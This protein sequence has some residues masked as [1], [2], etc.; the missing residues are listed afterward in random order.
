MR[1]DLAELLDSSSIPRSRIK[2]DNGIA[3]AF[4]I[5]VLQKNDEYI[6]IEDLD[7]NAVE[8]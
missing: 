8:W 5:N 3:T 4:V 6:P 2:K 1:F 7:F